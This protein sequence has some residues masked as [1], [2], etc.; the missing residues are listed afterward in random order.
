MIKMEND[1]AT[2]TSVQIPDPTTLVQRLMLMNAIKG[3]ISVTLITFFTLFNVRK[4]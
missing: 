4:S 2:Y 3:N 1:A